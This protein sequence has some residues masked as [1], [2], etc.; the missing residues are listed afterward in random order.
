MAYVQRPFPVDYPG[1]ICFPAHEGNVDERRPNTPRAIFLHTP[2][3]PVDDRESTPVY[4]S[5]N[6]GAA[7]HYY[8]DSDGD[9]Y[10][11]VPEAV[12]AIANGRRNKPRP[13]WAV[14]GVSLNLQ[15]ISVEI[16]GYAASIH[17]TMPR[18]GRQWNAVVRWIADRSRHHSIPL[19]RVHVMGH[20][21]VA[22]NRSD[23]GTLNIATIVADAQVLL[24]KETEPE[25][26][27]MQKPYL[28]AEQGSPYIFII[29]GNSRSY[30][31]DFKHADALDIPRDVK[32]VPKGTL[33]S[34]GRI[35]D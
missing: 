11:M 35:D 23:P 3:E 5:S 26:E 34:L 2:E 27:D 10:Q 24:E 30:L 33:G 15:S 28:A 9:W 16:E 1:S 6:R 17:R 29:W 18:G 19:D 14:P 21:E 31:Q 13:S 20:Y 12:G 32:R 25:E 4:F 7:T 8:S 22:D